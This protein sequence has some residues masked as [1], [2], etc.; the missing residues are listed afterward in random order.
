VAETNLDANSS[1][2]LHLRTPRRLSSQLSAAAADLV[3]LPPRLWKQA[4]APAHACRSRE[5]LVSLRTLSMFEPSAFH[6]RPMGKPLPSLSIQPCTG[7]TFK[8]AEFLPDS[9]HVS[10]RISVNFPDLLLDLDLISS[11]LPSA[12]KQSI[13]HGNSIRS[14]QRAP[15]PRANQPI[16][17]INQ[18]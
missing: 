6:I 11:P 17:R 7:I 5:Q 9:H 18:S 13:Q 3:R 12:I 8:W 15:R 2:H 14:R 16:H 10:L 4:L 1:T